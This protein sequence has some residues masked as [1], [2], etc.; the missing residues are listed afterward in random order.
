MA[1]NIADKKR[2]REYKLFNRVIIHTH[3]RRD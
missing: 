1:K 2:V 3:S